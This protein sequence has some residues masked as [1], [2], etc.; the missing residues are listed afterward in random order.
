MNTKISSRT[1]ARTMLL[2]IG[3]ICAASAQDNPLRRGR[4]HFQNGDYAKAAAAFEQGAATGDA[5]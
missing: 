4:T 1:A 2:G 5:G 3:L